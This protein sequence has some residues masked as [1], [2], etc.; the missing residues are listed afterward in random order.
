MSELILQGISYR[1][2]IDAI[3]S[4]QTKIGYNNALKRYMN[5]LK[6]TDVDNLL[7]NSNS[8]AI[9]AQII[10]YIMSLRQDGISY[11]TIRFLIAPIFTFYQLNDVVLNRK[12][13]SRYMGEFKRVVKDK[14]YSTE[15]ISQMLQNAD[16]RMRMMIL[17]L[18][19]TGCR[20]GSLA[21]L[22]L[23]NLTRKPEYGLYKITFYEGTNNEYYTFCTRECAATGIDPYLEFRNRCG[24]HLSFDERSQQ[25]TPNNTPLFRTQFDHSDSLQARQPKPISIHS[26]RTALASHLTKCGIRHYEHPLAP[27]PLGRIRK[28]IPLSN[29]FR[30]RVISIFIEAQLSHEIRELIVD[31]DTHLDQNYYRP[32][33]DQVLA[34]YLKA[35]QMLTIDPTLKMQQEIQTLRV[36]KSKMEQV[37]DRINKLEDKILN[38]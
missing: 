28:S 25:W 19:S 13:V 27:K 12:K 7:L 20:I 26:L 38:Q 34:E 32:S 5:H 23:G 10:D 22:T 15:Q 30:K 18:C 29:G 1:N 17:I 6:M 24:E 11:S 36:E 31:H 33:E 2:F 14:P 21:D 3:H 16:Q 35:E 37:L 9:E 4:P 8:K